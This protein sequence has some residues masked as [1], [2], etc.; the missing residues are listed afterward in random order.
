MQIKTSHLFV[1]YRCMPCRAIF[2]QTSSFHRSCQ[3]LRNK[4][5]ARPR[6]SLCSPTLFDPTTS[7]S[8][9]HTTFLIIASVAHYTPFSQRYVGVGVYFFFFMSTLQ[10]FFSHQKGKSYACHLCAFCTGQ[11]RKSCGCRETRS[12]CFE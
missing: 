12:R 3:S 6:S 5:R 1:F 9:R 10:S 8:L 7:K 2:D 4:L 11:S